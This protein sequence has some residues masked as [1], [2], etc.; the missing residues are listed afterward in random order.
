VKRYLLDGGPL[1]GWLF[2]RPPAR[3]LVR[4]WVANDEVATS[5]LVYGELVEYIAGFAN[6][7]KVKRDFLILL[8]DVT[9]LPLSIEIL[10]R[11]ADLRRAMRPPHGPGL[12]GDVD[13]LIA[14]TAL[15]HDLTVVTTDGDFTRVPGLRVML[16]ARK[17]FE[18]VRSS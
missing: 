9:P 7:A 17:T 16:L 11:Y 13:T 10:D 4:S 15:E 5:I 18:I 12:I 14:A 6:A 8:D 2:A 3:R 1:G